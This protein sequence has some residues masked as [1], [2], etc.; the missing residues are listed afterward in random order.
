MPT[1]IKITV[2]GLEFQ[3]QLN[4][5]ETGTLLSQALPL[6]GKASRWGKEYYFGVPVSAGLEDG[7]SEVVEPGELGYWPVG[8]ALC[9]FWGP[10]PASQGDE[11]RA[12]SKVNRVGMVEGDLESLTPLG[13][14]VAIRVEKA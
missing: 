5:S 7:A 11:C 2:Q 4:D 12:A 3:G 1:L 8:S 10:T 9:L 6:E 13:S 14:Q